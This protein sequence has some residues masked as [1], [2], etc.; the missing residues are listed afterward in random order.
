MGMPVGQLSY[1]GANEEE[2]VNLMGEAQH[3]LVGC[4]EAFSCTSSPPSRP[5]KPPTGPLQEKLVHWPRPL[6]YGA[7]GRTS[8]VGICTK[9]V[10]A[11]RCGIGWFSLT[12]ILQIGFLLLL[13]LAEPSQAVFVGFDNCLSP[14]VIN[15]DPKRL[16]FTPLLVWASFSTSASHSLNVT[17]FGNVTGQTTQE[18]LPNPLDPIWNDSNFTLGKIV[19]IPPNQHVKPPLATTLTGAFHVLDYTP[20]VIDATRFCNET[21]H[22]QCPIGPVFTNIS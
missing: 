14:S 10:Y 12:H 9:Q 18:S 19:D 13:T 8:S 15:S 6:K 4:D 2:T 7:R 22:G 11:Q 20:Y 5:P 16:Q 3:Q 21:V 1:N 17:V